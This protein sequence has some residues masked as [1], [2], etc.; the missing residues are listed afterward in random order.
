[1]PCYTKWNIPHGSYY[2]SVIFFSRQPQIYP[3]VPSPPSRFYT[4]SLM[5]PKNAP[6]SLCA[7]EAFTNTLAVKGHNDL[8]V[9]ILLCVYHLV[10]LTDFHS[11]GLSKLNLLGDTTLSSTR[12]LWMTHPMCIEILCFLSRLMYQQK[13]SLSHTHKQDL[14]SQTI[15]WKL[16][17]KYSMFTFFYIV[18]CCAQYHREQAG[19]MELR[20]HCVFY[21]KFQYM[22][23]STLVL[24][25][26]LSTTT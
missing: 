4:K 8:I 19:P 9:S 20:V 16:F 13:M 17:C 24:S 25:W 10:F 18:R 3:D 6:L 7:I 26:I 14:T 12:Y 11:F 21:L 15:C 22:L 2:D 5:T 23:T 1:M